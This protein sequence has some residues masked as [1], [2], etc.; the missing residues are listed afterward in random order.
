MN[1]GTEGWVLV[2][3]GGLLALVSNV[4]YMLGGTQGFSKL[5]RRFCASSILAGCACFLALAN[6]SWN[7]LYLA[8][9]PCLMLGF[10]MG[11]GGEELWYKVMRRSVY[12]FGVLSACV[13][14]AWINSFSASSI[15]VLI[16]AAIT[17]LTSVALG[18]LNPFKSAR[19]EEFLVC[20]VLT[21]YVPFWCYIK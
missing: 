15:T 18:V 2:A 3:I 4:M 12:A 8:F 21:L 1:W 14:G 7:W 20:Q 16:L 19:L 10:S 13:F 5:I 9:F 17:G 6:S 11:Y